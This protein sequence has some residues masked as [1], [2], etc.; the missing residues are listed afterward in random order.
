[1]KIP[2]FLE[3]LQ[4]FHIFRTIWATKTYDLS[5]ERKL[6]ETFKCLIHIYLLPVSTV[7]EAGMIIRLNLVAHMAIPKIPHGHADDT[8]AVTINIFLSFLG[9]GRGVLPGKD[10][11]AW[12]ENNKSSSG[13][14]YPYNTLFKI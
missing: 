13:R 6:P 7:R 3:K 5:S 10:G 11:M 12:S 4:N 14:K 8:L 2:G 1:M 9:R